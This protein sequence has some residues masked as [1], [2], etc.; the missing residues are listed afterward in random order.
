MVSLCF[1][2]V[3]SL[4]WF[5][6]SCQFQCI[7]LLGKILWN[8]L[9]CVKWDIKL[10]SNSLVMLYYSVTAGDCVVSKYVAC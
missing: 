4:G 5:E 8:D 6:C 9:L 2:C 3:F 1:W 10:L 7:R